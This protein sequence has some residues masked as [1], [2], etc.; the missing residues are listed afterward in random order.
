MLAM[1]RSTTLALAAAALTAAFVLPA[2]AA[3]QTKGADVA[4]KSEE[5][6]DT[7]KAY[8][9]EKKNDA[10]SFGK[11]LIKESDD[12]LAQLD[13]KAA[14]A[15]GEAKTQYQKDIKELKA[16]RARA[17]AKLREM[18]KAS[19][20]AWDATKNGFAEAYKDLHQSYNKA[21]AQFK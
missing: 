5:A 9:V 13:R 19:G 4:K 18:E 2:P 14:K 10:V 7:V 15:S 1:L 8:T 12:K 21:V 11:K 6:W 16:A 17:A 20:A 3:A